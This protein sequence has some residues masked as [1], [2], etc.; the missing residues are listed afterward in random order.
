VQVFHLPVKEL[1][2]FLLCICCT[3]TVT[4]HSTSP[5]CCCPASLTATHTNSCIVTVSKCYWTV[6]ICT[7]LGKIHI[8]IYDAVRFCSIDGRRV[9]CECGLVLV[10]ELWIWAGFGLKHRGKCMFLWG[11]TVPITICPPHT[12]I[13]LKTDHCSDRLLTNCTS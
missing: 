7:A 9:N 11:E 3:G 5:H 8:L 4:F 12:H 6:A 2:Y 1:L 13:C 10:S